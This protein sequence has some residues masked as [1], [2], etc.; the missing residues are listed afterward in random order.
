M[1]GSIR[2]LTT[3]GTPK[4]ETHDFTSMYIDQSI[5]ILLSF[6]LH[7]KWY[8]NEKNFKFVFCLSLGD[9][10]RIDLFT[11]LNPTT[12]PGDCEA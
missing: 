3:V 11:I 5:K 1:Y 10:N 7:R 2:V 8:Q 12:C 9:D 4:S 6:G